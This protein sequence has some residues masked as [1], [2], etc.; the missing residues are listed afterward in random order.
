MKK[1]FSFMLVMMIA[2][3]L[4]LSA[5]GAKKNN[6]GGSATNG[7]TKV[8][9]D[10]T[11]KG[12]K[13]GMVTDVG[14]VHDKSFNES[15]WEALQRVTAET[16]ADTKFLESKGEA[17]LEPNLNSFVK[18]GYDLTWGIGF[19]FNDALAKVAAENPNAKL[20]VIDSVI[21]VPNVASIVFAENEGSFLVGVVA[22]LMTKTNKIGFVGGM[23]I[24]VIKNFEV[25]FKAG[26]AAV[27]PDAT[28]KIDYA[29][30][31]GKPDLG[32]L[33]AAT[34][35]DAGV[36]IIFHAAGATGNG[37]FNEAIARK[38]AGDD[39]WVIG[40]DKDQSLEYGDEVTLTS[41]M[42]GVEA[43]VHK[44]SKDVIAGTF[45]GGKIQKLG[46]KD[47]AVGLPE[48][49]KNLPEDVLAEVAK[50]KEKIISGEIK[51]PTA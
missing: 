37:V 16:S 42:K 30:D 21:E 40:V 5:C 34:M 28:V 26:V 1:T 22:G 44:I 43:A 31:F 29:G 23:E 8:V 51:V 17:D 24:P 38:S 20:A 10:E 47:D 27:K 9:S 46:L 36:D 45:A 4:V 50:Y 41:M 32:K 7:G 13:I 18:E 11:G 35:Y 48:T 15:A 39:V 2:L 12:I 14:G 3:T 6:E 19:L 33:S 49:T 25:G